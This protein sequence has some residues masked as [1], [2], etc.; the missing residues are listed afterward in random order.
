[1]QFDILGFKCHDIWC[2]DNEL[3]NELAND[4]ILTFKT[5]AVSMV[6]IKAQSQCPTLNPHGLS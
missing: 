4:D 2:S 5:V 3:L 1:M 6:D